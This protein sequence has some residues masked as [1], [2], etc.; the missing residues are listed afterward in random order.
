MAG[1]KNN[2]H[3]ARETSLIMA[4]IKNFHIGIKAV[5][6]NGNKALVVKDTKR[7]KGYDLPGGKIDDGEGIEQ[8]LKRE[9]YEELGL[10]KF[11]AGEILFAFERSDYNKKGASIMLLFYKVEAKIT[12]I[13]LS[14]EHTDFLWIS[15]KDL[16]RIK[17]R[18]SGVKTAL[19]KVFSRY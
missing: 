5:I 9:L 12:K 13:K 6:V 17:F 15:K 3:T 7:F 18:N 4:S 11:S 16:S 2:S 14:N 1:R 8:A 10:K 19:E